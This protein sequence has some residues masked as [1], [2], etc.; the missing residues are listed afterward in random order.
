MP[1]E[2]GAAK[3]EAAAR[4]TW[5]RYLEA[6]APYITALIVTPLLDPAGAPPSLRELH[7]QLWEVGITPPWMAKH[8]YLSDMNLEAGRWWTLVLHQFAHSD[9][10]HL[11]NNLLSIVLFGRSVHE[12][13]GSTEAF[14]A[15]LVGGATATGYLQVLGKREEGQRFADLQGL[16][17]RLPL[18]DASKAGRWYA[19]TV[20]R[21]AGFMTRQ[22]APVLPIPALGASGGAC[23]L[24]GASVVVNVEELVDMASKLLRVRRRS[25]E[26]QQVVLKRSAV[27]LVLTSAF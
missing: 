7:A 16:L 8:V 4:E 1:A 5:A 11:S 20:D 25:R 6:L 2:G 21:F 19:A 13:L 24:M 15:L 17:P 12:R 22:L 26:E 3:A 9:I 10:N 23:C 27:R 18:G 14:Y